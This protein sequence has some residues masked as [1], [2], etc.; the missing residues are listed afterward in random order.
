MVYIEGADRNTG[1]G[2]CGGR[3]YL[4]SIQ[5]EAAASKEEVLLECTWHDTRRTI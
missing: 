1:S 4:Y 2:G 3:S 5:Q